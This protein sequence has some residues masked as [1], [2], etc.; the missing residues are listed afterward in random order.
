MKPPR[1]RRHHGHSHP[2]NGASPADAPP[3]LLASDALARVFA[4]P[5][6]LRDLG[7]MAWLLVGVLLL[8]AGGVWLLTLTAVIVV[9]VLTAS[10]IA[11]VLS[12]VVSWL[13]GHR[14]RR[15]GGGA[16]VLLPG[17][18]VGGGPLFLPAF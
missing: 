14:L 5:S 16:G 10:I 8:I 9:P 11:A 6:W 17:L 15:R 4:V 2:D 7:L 12:P 13:A 18:A 3:V 1:L